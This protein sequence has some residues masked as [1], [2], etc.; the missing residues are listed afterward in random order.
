MSAEFGFFGFLRKMP[1]GEK[2]PKEPIQEKETIDPD[3]Y[4]QKV[5]DM[6]SVCNI[7]YPGCWDDDVLETAFPPEE[8]FYLDKD[9]NEFDPPR[10]H[11]V[12]AD[13]LDAPFEDG[14]FDAAFIQDMHET[15]EELA[16]ILK[17]VKSQGIVIYSSNECGM[18]YGA[19]FDT[20]LATDG[21]SEVDLPFET[22]YFRTFLWGKIP[23]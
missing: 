3:I 9:P 11:Y 1:E 7:Y 23:S 4:L 20:F 13:V 8:I 6:F 16:A 17:K 21:I 12:Q 5:R 15:P 10:P 2:V 14:F 18:N 19:E 22:Y